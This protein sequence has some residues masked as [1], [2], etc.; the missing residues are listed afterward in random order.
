MQLVKNIHLTPYNTFHLEAMASRF[1]VVKELKEFLVWL[2]QNPQAIGQIKILGGGSNILLTQSVD[3]YV[4]KNELKGIEKIV[5]DEQSVHI[6]FGSGENWHECVLWAVERNLGG[7][8]NLAL[9]PGTIGAAP[10]QNIGAYGVELK[11]VF[12]ECSALHL[13]SG[14]IHHFSNEEC[15]FGYRDSIFKQE[16]RGQY[17]ITSVTLALHKKPVYKTDYGDISKTIQEEYNGEISI[18][19]IAKA[20][21]KIRSSKLPDPAQIGNA[22]SFF[23]N[24]VI[25]LQQFEGLKNE[26]PNIPSY[27]VPNGTKIPAAWLIEQCG[28][29]GFSDGEIGVHDRQALVLINKGK[30]KGIDILTL[31][32]RIIT[33]VQ[34]RFNIVL[35]REVNIW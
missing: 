3:G 26:H 30:G 21:I 20:V 33:S 35:E 14:D 31:S 19:T 25:S 22:G 10:I 23:K 16:Q 32:E 18:Q 15:R 34:H 28:W 17:F 1:L 8:E 27:P 9:I 29:K 12:V 24:P 11:D 7:I 5:E 4:I 13:E 2:K 6:R